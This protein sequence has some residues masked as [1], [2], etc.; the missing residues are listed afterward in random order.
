MQ[1]FFERL[2]TERL[3]SGITLEEIFNKTRISIEYLTAIEEGELKKLP[4]GYDRI[5]MKSYLQT[6]GIDVDSYLEEFDRLLGRREPT[7]VIDLEDLERDR[8]K[9]EINLNHSLKYL[10]L[11]MPVVLI[12][13]F[14]I[15]LF[16]SFGDDEVQTDEA[17]AQIPEIKVEDYISDLDTIQTAMEVPEPE[18]IDSLKVNLT[19][20]KR[21]WVRAVIDWRD[22]VEFTLTK[23]L[24]R[25]LEADSVMHFVIGVGDGISIQTTDSVYRNIAPSGQVIKRLVLDSKGIREIIHSL[26]ASSNSEQ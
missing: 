19:G 24:I 2:K 4:K 8:Q 12:L 25:T 14:L 21:T 13:S 17:A 1:D 7:Q 6:I 26:P 11:W 10:L 16:I 15:Y 22:T 3:D 23:D 5:F 20:I 9:R 18:T